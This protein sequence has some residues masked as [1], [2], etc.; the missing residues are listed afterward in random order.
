MAESSNLPK[1]EKIYYSSNKY[2][3]NYAPVIKEL[4]IRVS[5]EENTNFIKHFK[6]LMNGRKF[7]KALFINCGNGWVE[8]EFYK[9][10]LFDEAVG[11]DIFEPLLEEA[12]EKAKDMPIRYYKVDINAALFPEDNY[13]LVVNHA[14]CHHITYLDKVLRKINKILTVDG[15]FLN[16]DYVGPH[17]N[18]YPFIQWYK[19]WELNRKLPKNMRQVLAYAYLPEM[20]HSDP[21]EAVHSELI[22]NTTKRYFNF[23]VHKH[24][25]GA[26]AYPILTFNNNLDNIDQEQLSY[27]IKFVLD[28][29]MKFTE[30]TGISLFDYY[31]C[32][33]NKEI[34]SNEK[35]LSI[36]TKE[37]EKREE[38]A[39]QNGG[40]YY[41]STIVY[42]MNYMVPTLQKI[43]DIILRA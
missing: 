40:K 27:W 29:D 41:N 7:K 36:F 26:L 3:N 2:W 8:R 43:K 15:Y 13:D 12:R 6:K 18:Q 23:I 10:N 24:L 38:L 16:Y 4:N 19:T 39:R 37:E 9:N 32:T 35:L 30:R 5:G 14:A 20:L 17:R 42:K 31:I 11:V 1:S 25:G 34:L 22:I 21:S 33:P 28:K